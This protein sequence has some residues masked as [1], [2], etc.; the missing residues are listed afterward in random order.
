MF[1]NTGPRIVTVR[2]VL[3]LVDTIVTILLP[4]LCL[5]LLLLAL[6]LPLLI[7]SSDDDE[8]DDHHRCICLNGVGI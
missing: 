8:D 5:L 4:C 7:T 3:M 2:N 6:S 1:L